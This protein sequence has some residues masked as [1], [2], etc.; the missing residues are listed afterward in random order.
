MLRPHGKDLARK[1]VRVKALEP[2]VARGKALSFI[3]EFPRYKK[4]EYL[5]VGFLVAGKVQEIWFNGDKD[6]RHCQS[7]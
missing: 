1:F 5:L 7:R 3:A 4:N 2:R 6:K